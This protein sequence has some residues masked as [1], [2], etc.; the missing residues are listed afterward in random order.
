[1]GDYIGTLQQTWH[2]SERDI[3]EFV[4][5]KRLKGVSEKT[6]NDEVRYIRRA[7]AELD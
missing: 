2:V 1:L 3:E 6:I 4:K 7:L 5:A